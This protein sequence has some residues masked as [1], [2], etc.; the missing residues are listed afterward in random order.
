MS[1]FSK[2]YNLPYDIL[3]SAMVR[4]NRLLFTDLFRILFLIQFWIRIRIRIRNVYFGSGS[5]QKFRILTDPD[6][7]HCLEV[8]LCLKTINYAIFLSAMVR[9]NHA[10]LGRRNIDF[11]RAVFYQ[12]ID[13]WYSVFIGRQATDS[14]RAGESEVRLPEDQRMEDLSPGHRH[15]W[16]YRHGGR[17]WFSSDMR[18]WTQKFTS[19]GNRIRICR[20]QSVPSHWKNFFLHFFILFSNI[21]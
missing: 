3:L 19:M 8:F 20:I 10:V 17:N 13:P 1:I 9:E 18:I 4:E 7:Q 11:W 6:P 16:H 21:L 5:G 14:E 2:N 15:G 12:N